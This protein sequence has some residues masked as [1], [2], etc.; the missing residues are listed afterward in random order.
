MTVNR[1]DDL[2]L[3]R[4]YKDGDQQALT[5]LMTNFEGMLNRW[6]SVHKTPAL[7]PYVMRQE[8]L[9]HLKKAIDTYDPSHGAKLSTHV[10]WALKK[11]TRLINRHANPGRLP[12]QRAL[13]IGRFEEAR[14]ELGERFGRPATAQELADHFKADFTLSPQKQKDFSLKQITR[15]EKEIRHEVIPDEGFGDFAKDESDARE[16]MAINYVYD[17]LPSKDQAIFEHLTGF[18]GKP[19]LKANKIAKMFS[20]SPTTIGKKKKRFAEMLQQVLPA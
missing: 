1:E 8:A 9:T 6:L 20:V 14:T 13:M 19:I 17:S 10:H 5:P 4:R 15:L 18:G 11:G 3:W 12:D 7:P 16:D 2:T